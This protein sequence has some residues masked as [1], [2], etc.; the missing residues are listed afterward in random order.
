MPCASSPTALL[1]TTRNVSPNASAI[2]S[3]TSFNTENRCARTTASAPLGTDAKL[4]IYLVVLNV[5]L[6]Q[7]IA[8]NCDPSSEW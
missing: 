6:K 1:G 5:A 2:S 8:S 3:M 4:P 7:M